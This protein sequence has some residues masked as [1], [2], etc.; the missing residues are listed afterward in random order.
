MKY[1]GSCYLFEK[2]YD[3]ATMKKKAY[4]DLNSF[5]SPVSEF[6]FLVIPNTV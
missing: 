1:Y 5:I 3:D 2:K 6:L 4:I